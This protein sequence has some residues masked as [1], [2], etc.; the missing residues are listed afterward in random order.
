M[1]LYDISAEIAAIEQSLRSSVDSEELEK[2]MREA[3]E[4][5]QCDLES[6]VIGCCALYKNLQA[7]AAACAEESKR[8]AMR[9]KLNEARAERLKD[10]L[11]YYIKPGTK[12]ENA[13]HSVTWRKSEV[14]HVRE[15]ADIPDTYLKPQPPKIDKAQIKADLKRGAELEFAWIENKINMGIK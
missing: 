5:A 15:W 1:R 12:I 9:A 13:I 2:N 6:K 10:L 8:L 3:W 4:A 11:R 7:A 14:C